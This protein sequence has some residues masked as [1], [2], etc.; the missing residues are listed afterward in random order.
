MGTGT[1][2]GTEKRAV[3]ETETE[4]ETG[5]RA[6]ME[7]RAIV[8]TA[9]KGGGDGDG[10]RNGIRDGIGNENGEGRGGGGEL[11]Y[12][13]HQEISKAE[14]QTLLYRSWYHLCRQEPA[15]AGS[16]Q[17]WAR[18]SAPA[19][20]CGTEGRIGHHGREGGNNDGNRDGDGDRD[21]REDGYGNKNKGR[22]GSENGSGNGNDYR[23]ERGEE[24]KPGILRSGNRGRAE[25]ARGRAMPTSNQ[26]P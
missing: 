20:G 22:D 23:E 2:A 3:V 5:T 21:G 13:P 16:Q 14:D 17:S 25:D 4:T 7:T 15:P 26:Q 6:G 12:P 18:D 10:G 9:H 19:R 24:R 11:W 1:E 8:E